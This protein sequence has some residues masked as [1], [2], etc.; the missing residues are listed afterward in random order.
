MKQLKTISTIFDNFFCLL[1]LFV[2]QFLF[3]F[4]CISSY[5]ALSFWFRVE[6]E[7]TDILVGASSLAARY[8]RALD[9]R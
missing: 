2:P 1:T 7:R 3:Y 6:R 9:K 4:I 8:E 5:A